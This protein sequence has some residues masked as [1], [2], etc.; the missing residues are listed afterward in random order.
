MISSAFNLMKKDQSK[1]LRFISNPCF[2]VTSL[3]KTLYIGV[4][5]SGHAN[6][7]ISNENASC[8]KIAQLINAAQLC[9][10]ILYQ[11]H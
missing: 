2:D 11:L 7:M 3:V 5:K 4:P 6:F 9:I 8:Y 1:D 10:N